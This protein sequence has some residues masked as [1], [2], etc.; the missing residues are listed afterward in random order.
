M[1]MGL[2]FPSD[3]NKFWSLMGGQKLAYRSH[4]LLCQISVALPDQRT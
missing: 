4:G 1:G 3:P 2:G